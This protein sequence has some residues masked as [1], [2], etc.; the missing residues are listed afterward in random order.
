LIRLAL[1]DVPP[2]GNKNLDALVKV[3][4]AAGTTMDINGCFSA[5]DGQV[6]CSTLRI[7]VR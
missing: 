3:I 2:R 1:P 6:G 4:A 5:N 7:Q